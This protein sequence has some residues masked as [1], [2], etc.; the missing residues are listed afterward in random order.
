MRE[1]CR[2]WD[3]HRQLEDRQLEDPLEIIIE[4][5][6]AECC[7]A[8][9]EA[10]TKTSRVNPIIAIPID[11]TWVNYLNEALLLLSP[12]QVAI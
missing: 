9:I 7:Q 6:N 10:C 11:A 8:L 5:T 12:S 4:K 2:T 3:N 1:S